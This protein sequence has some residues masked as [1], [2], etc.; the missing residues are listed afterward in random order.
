MI[1]F[2]PAELTVPAVQFPANAGVVEAMQQALW[3]MSDLIPDNSLV[4][5]ILHVLVGCTG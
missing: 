5:R 4:G 3:N 2:L 1:T